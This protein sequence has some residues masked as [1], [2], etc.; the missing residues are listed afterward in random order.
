[1]TSES[2]AQAENRGYADA[3]AGRKYDGSRFPAGSTLEDAYW[4]GWDSGECDRPSLE[5]LTLDVAKE[6]SDPFGY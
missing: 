4:C 3:M 5:E 1:M 2:N 6:R